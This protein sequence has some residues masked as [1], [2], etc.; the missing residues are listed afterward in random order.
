MSSCEHVSTTSQCDTNIPANCFLNSANGHGEPLTEDDLKNKFGVT[1]ADLLSHT[2]DVPEITITFDTEIGTN[3][4]IDAS[5]NS[6]DNEKVEHGNEHGSQDDQ[7]NIEAKNEQEVKVAI[8][9]GK[10]YLPCSK[11][12][13]E[14]PQ[15]D[16]MNPTEPANLVNEGQ[17]YFKAWPSP[18]ERHGEGRC[19]DRT[20][21]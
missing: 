16:S 3:P 13:K 12:G 4:N 2:T 10:N 8:N 1:Q 18:Q 21:S 5:G 14:S 19:Y 15:N 20:A 9:S 11:N 17:F 7:A 6:E